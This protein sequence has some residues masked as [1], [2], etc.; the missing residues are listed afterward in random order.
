[1][2]NSPALRAQSLH[3]PIRIT[4]FFV[5]G[6]AAIAAASPVLAQTV[7]TDKADYYPGE[8]VIVTG[9]GWLPGERVSLFFSETPYQ[10]VPLT[11]YAEADSTGAI[12][13][14][15]YL[16]QPYHL[17]TSFVLTAYGLTSELMA[18]TA[19]TD[20]PKVGSV[21]AGTQSGVPCAGTSGQATYTVTVNRGTGGGS[22]GN[23]TATLS[24]TSGLPSGVS[25]SF[26]PNPVQLVSS[27]SSASA[28]MTLTTSAGTPSGT[29]TITVKAATSASDTAATSATF[30]VNQPPTITSPGNQ[31]AANAAGQCG[32]A[33]SFAATAT[34]SPAPTLTYSQNPGTVFPVGVT[35]VTATAT[36]ACGSTNTTFTVTV[37]DTEKPTIAT[38]NVTV[39]T[40]GGCGATVAS[41][42]TTASDNCPGVTLVGVR[43]DAALLAA[44]FPVGTT[45]ITWTATDAHGN[46]KTAT[47]T[48]TVED[49]ENP[50][51]SA[52]ADLTV[53][54][55]A[56]AAACG[57]AVAD[58]A[59]G[60]ASATDN[61]SATIERTGV[62]A[63]S[64][65]PVGTTTITYTAK[66]PSGNTDTKTQAITVVDDTPPT[67]E[68]PATVHLGTG[69]GATQCALLVSD[70]TLGTPTAN[71]NCSADVTRSGVP[72][73]NLFPVG[74]TTI[75]WTAK[76]PAGNTATATQTVIVD[77]TTPP[78]I[79]TAPITTQTAGSCGALVADL[80]TTAADQCGPATLSG[81]R[82]D[83]AALAAEFPTGTTTIT[84]TASDAAGNTSSATQT[85]AVEDHENP[86]L[87]APGNVTVNT[88]ADATACGAAVSDATL[89]TATATD[90][91]SAI[92][93]RAGIPAGGFF[94]V[95]TTTITYT[96]TDPSGN[97]VSETQ[98]VTV[99]DTTPPAISTGT[100][101]VSTG[102]GICTATIE[103]LG[104][105]AADNCGG[106]T[107]TGVRSDGAPLAA[108][109]SIGTTTIAWT[110]TDLAGNTTAATQTVKVSDHQAP[111][112][113][114][115]P[116]LSLVTGPGATTC[117][118]MISDGTL[119]TPAASDNCS[120]SVTRAGVPDA[121]V[122]PIGTTTITW[123]ATDPS[124][125]ATSGTQTVTVTDNT[126][127]VVT[128]PAAIDL[129]TGPSATTCGLVVADAALGTA[130]ATDNCSATVTRTGVPS[131]NLFPVGTTTLTYTATDGAGN[132]ASA[133]QTVTITDNTPPSITTANLDAVTSAGVCGATVTLGT[134]ATD[135]CSVSS[136]V[137][138]RSDGAAI[139]ASFPLGVTTITWV[140][141]DPAGNTK[142]ATQTVTVTNPTPTALVTSPASG[143]LYAA[144]STITMSGTFTDNAGDLHT[145]RWVCDALTFPGTVNESAKTV[146]GTMNFTAAGVYCVRLEVTDQ[147]GNTASTTTI[148][149]LQAMVVV[150]DPSAGFVTGGG[151][152]DSP[153]GAYPAVPALTGKANFGFVSKYKKGQSTPTG[154]TEFQFKAG[155][156]NFHSTSYDWLVVSGAKAQ[157]KGSGQINGAGNFGFLLTST[158]GQA[159]GGGGKDKF[160]IKIVDKLSGATVYDNQMGA[161]DTASAVC[162]L[163]GGSIVIQSQGGALAAA[164]FGDGAPD[165][166]ASADGAMG[167]GGAA[168]AD[169]AA[170][171]VGAVATTAI[172]QNA[173]NPFNPQTMVRFALAEAGRATVRVF[174]ARGELVKT[175]AEG[176]FPA[177]AHAASWNGATTAGGRA[178]SGVY[179]AVLETARFRGQVRMILIK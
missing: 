50:V 146:T 7:T 41:L 46:T 106:T 166:A 92:V 114:P 128:A 49:H 135:N 56:A 111:S 143:A 117:G 4:L 74:T 139:D 99:V 113:T 77:D 79:A 133:T 10:F 173:P 53:N 104:T 145:A 110:A 91:C 100:L 25:A 30:T 72:S 21:V 81:V 66:D 55:G 131:G 125:N 94:P 105:T 97:S 159:P 115:P 1:M 73:G 119:G 160:R 58:A 167:A 26:S 51:L 33:V 85:V 40:A 121:N 70:A 60:T 5:L 112:L 75:T 28:T 178:A 177:G 171:A 43:S 140:A 52:P 38:S 137:G 126:P 23:F 116:A 42:G 29:S 152:I 102:D 149:G 36:N 148:G 136:L 39:S 157:F 168:G 16:I 164:A 153:T 35:T 123:T 130:T 129:M 151:W 134:T 11:L 54:T 44:L 45:T 48:V 169:G 103:S 161:A 144:G 18:Q 62:P 8:T 179:Y 101:D 37:N 69:A 15:E 19:F 122:F 65:F 174:N 89:G 98:L 108:P 63:G 27:A 24:V 175:V 61:C 176:W 170:G 82:S 78:T 59:L 83:G 17:G 31:T 142:S 6:L 9:N 107:L 96:A 76:D 80:G 3:G 156:L 165:G 162:V 34:G 90:N 109:F 163:G 2:T 87:S 84:W 14:D 47:Q 118:L 132:T 71:D 150:Y 88:G 68:A 67:I 13:S 120:F 138:T 172:F 154:E 124:G 12:Y 86:V 147:C 95:G 32:A 127:P 141:T 155:D 57:A 22:P 64:F 93:E 158:D 20:S